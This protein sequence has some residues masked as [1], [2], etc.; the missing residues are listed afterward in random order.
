M[1]THLTKR[2]P[3]RNMARFYRL[4]MLPNL[5]GEWTL[6]REWGRIGSPGQLRLDYHKSR[7]S[8]EAAF[9]AL[10]RRKVRRG[11]VAPE[12][13]PPQRHLAGE[14]ATPPVPAT[15]TSKPPMS[16][17]DH[18]FLK[19]PTFLRRSRPPPCTAGA[20]RSDERSA[21]IGSPLRDSSTKKEAPTGYTSYLIHNGLEIPALP[22]GRRIIHAKR[23]RKWVLIWR[24][25]GRVRVRARHRDFDRV[26]VESS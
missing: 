17:G 25:K 24:G 21:D 23:G 2:D 20:G 6:M 3:A 26:V 14:P 19:I 12:H 4:V 9:A 8:A 7:D 13:R 15:T 1:D 5:F 18:D 11:Y 16:H 10:K 22:S